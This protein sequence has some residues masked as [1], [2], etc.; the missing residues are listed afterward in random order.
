MQTIA[1][2]N[3]KG[4]TAKTTTSVNLAATLGELGKKV[5]LVDLDGQ[6]ASSRWLEIEDDPRLA[7]ALLAGGGL[8]PIDD[9][10]PGVSLAPASGKLDS[11]SH[12]LRPTQGGQLRRVLAE[13][14]DRYDYVLIDCPPSLGNRLIG[15]ALLAASHAIVPVETSILALDGL[16]ILLIMLDDIRQ[17]FD[18]DIEL[19]GALA[20]RYN[21][22]TRLSRLVLAELHRALPGKVFNTIIHETVRMQEC[23]AVG[24]SILDYAPDCSA[25]KDYRALARELVSGI[26]PVRSDHIAGDLTDSDELDESDRKAVLDFR[27]RAVE[28]FCRP[29]R[30]AATTDPPTEPGD[31]EETHKPRLPNQADSRGTGPQADEPPDSLETRTVGAEPAGVPL[32]RDE[33]ATPAGPEPM[34]ETT[35]ESEDVASGLPRESVGPERLDDEPDRAVYE[36]ELYQPPPAGRRHDIVIV[37][38]VAVLLIIVCVCGLAGLYTFKPD[39]SQASGRTSQTPAPVDRKSLLSDVA[40]VVEDMQ[41]PEPA[42]MNTGPFAAEGETHR[43]TGTDQQTAASE[44]SKARLDRPKTVPDK[45]GDSTKKSVEKLARESASGVA[46][47]KAKPTSRP[48]KAVKAP[49]PPRRAA[50]AEDYPKGLTLSGIMNSPTTSRAIISGMVV[51]EGEKVKG[52]KVT[53]IFTDSVELE[54]NGYRFV[55]G[56]GPEPVWLKSTPI[57]IPH[58]TNQTPKAGN[59]EDE[60][61]AERDSGDTD[62]CDTDSDD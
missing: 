31:D 4:G 37:D 36:V 47:P 11:V 26:A 28:M 32:E 57:P 14:Q 33:A 45:P 35:D 23:P 48:S 27:K 42:V 39:P 30:T 1:I 16:R 40:K 24:K 58:E 18:H 50:R 25:G 61:P 43:K 55:L 62:S 60:G 41:T 19:I 59:S 34:A 20:C 7:D 8:E 13:L 54:A 22:R 9:I 3:E 56:T 52:V 29:R 10:L 6:A 49:T 17:G 5:L 21:S 15:N 38:A 12:N 51:C 2:L 53:R 46:A 44:T